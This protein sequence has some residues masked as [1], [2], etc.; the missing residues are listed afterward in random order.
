MARQDIDGFVGHVAGGM[1]AVGLAMHY[2]MQA[3]AAAREAR[4]ADEWAAYH[5]KCAR[6]RD[7]D[8]TDIQV[9]QMMR[10]FARRGAELQR[11][12]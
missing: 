6:Q 11:A 1:F 5:A 3:A 8:A 2:S 9:G 12:A 7:Q 4:R 10:A